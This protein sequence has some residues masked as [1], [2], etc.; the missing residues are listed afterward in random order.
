[1]SPIV[2]AA[3]VAGCGIGTIG[4]FQLA[5]AGR[6]GLMPWATVVAN[7]AGSALLGFLVC[8]TGPA[9]DTW[10]LVGGSGVA[11]GL[12]TFST[13]AIDAAELWRCGN[14]RGCV[15]YL[16]ATTI[17]GLVAA[18]LGWALASAVGG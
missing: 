17:G 6:R 8:S 2:W 15:V 13:L 5:A 18:A 10:R 9:T 1:M 16:A 12:T 11:G 4:R 7:L 3:A 14:R